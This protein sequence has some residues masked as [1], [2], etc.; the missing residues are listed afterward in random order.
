MYNTILGHTPTM[1]H[2][3]QRMKHGGLWSIQGR[4]QEV[5][6]DTTP[7]KSNPLFLGEGAVEPNKAKFG[8]G[9]DA[10]DGIGEDEV[11][12]WG[13]LQLGATQVLD[14]D[15]TKVTLQVSDV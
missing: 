14:G 12:S 1:T 15:V 13:S 11:V 10:I 5:W 9:E 7:T 3:R 2:Q 8:R 6:Q 4:S